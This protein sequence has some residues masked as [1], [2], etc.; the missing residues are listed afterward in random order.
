M[1]VVEGALPFLS[2]ASA[3]LILAE[4]GKIA[5][6]EYPGE[7]NWIEFSLRSPNGVF[8]KDFRQQKEKCECTVQDIGYYP[9]FVLKSKFWK[10]S[11]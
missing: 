8:R 11:M 5:T 6:P 1:K 4:M 9:D 7:D 10:Y 2:P 3:I